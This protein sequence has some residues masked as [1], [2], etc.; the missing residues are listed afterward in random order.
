MSCLSLK[1]NCASSPNTAVKSECSRRREQVTVFDGS[2]N[3][4][5]CF[6]PSLQNL[7]KKND[8]CSETKSISP[9]GND[10]SV[11]INKLPPDTIYQGQ[12]GHPKKSTAV[13]KP[14]CSAACPSCNRSVNY[15]QYS[16]EKRIFTQLALIVIAFMI[17]YIPQS[18]YLLWTSTWE[19][20]DDSPS[21]SLDYWFGVASYLCLRL[22][23]CMNP[24]MYNLGS[25]NMRHASKVFLR[26]FACRFRKGESSTI[27]Q[28]SIHNR[29]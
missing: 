25:S 17:G 19:I 3:G 8:S 10:A 29:R 24:L 5:Q 22:S 11:V 13:K 14:G 12:S 9:T 4:N 20:K 16:R 15:L 2:S 1:P 6:S 23:E 18:V 27:N 21:C 28:A 26:K 7:G